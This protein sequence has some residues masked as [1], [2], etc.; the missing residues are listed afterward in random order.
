MEREKKKISGRETPRERERERGAA[1]HFSAGE[2]VAELKE[3]IHHHPI[4]ERKRLDEKEKKNLAWL[5][6]LST[7][8]P[9]SKTF[10]W[11][12]PLFFLF[13]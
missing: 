8:S 5:A 11:A 3:R 9:P 6:H 12:G 1:L 4:V 13:S 10:G 2:A 7:S